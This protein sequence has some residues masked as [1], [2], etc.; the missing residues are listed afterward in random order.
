MPFPE[1][2]LFEPANAD[3]PCLDPRGPERF[4][5]LCGS[6][7]PTP[8]ESDLRTCPPSGVDDKKL[9]VTCVEA[10][11]PH[12]YMCEK[13]FSPGPPRAERAGGVLERAFLPLNEPRPLPTSRLNE[14]AARAEMLSALPEFTPG[15]DTIE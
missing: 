15:F 9:L 14:R 12:V 8:G 5:T 7:D 11:L 10:L 6:Y 4:S 13:S 1:R 3:V 2:P